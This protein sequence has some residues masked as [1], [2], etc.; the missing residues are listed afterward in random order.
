MQQD[1]RMVLVVQGDDTTTYYQVWLENPCPE[2][3]THVVTNRLCEEEGVKTDSAHMWMQGVL[4]HAVATL[5]LCGAVEA[6]DNAI[7]AIL[8]ATRA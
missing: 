2:H 8:E 3:G 4:E 1:K 7:T 6:E 5:C